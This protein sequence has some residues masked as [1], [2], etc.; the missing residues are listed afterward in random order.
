M[1]A[2]VTLAQVPKVVGGVGVEAAAV[3]ATV[4]LADEDVPPAPAQ[5][6]V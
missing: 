6:S 1:F 4:V 2:G 3:T 5:A